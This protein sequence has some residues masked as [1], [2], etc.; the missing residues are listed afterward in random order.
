MIKVTDSNYHDVVRLLVK[1][2]RM[3]QRGTNLQNIP[4]KGNGELVRRCFVPPKGWVLI[5]AD[6]SSIEPRIMSHILWTRY[7]DNSMRGPYLEGGDPYVDVGMMVFDIPREWALDK[8]WYDPISK[9]GGTAETKSQAPDTAFQPRKLAKQGLLAV[10]YGQTAKAF[11]K[12]LGVDESVAEHFLK[13]FNEMYPNFKHKMVKEIVDEMKEKGFSQ[14][15]F[16]RKRRF[17][18]YQMYQQM[19]QRSE[20]ELRE[21][22]IKRKQLVQVKNPTPQQKKRFEQI[23][24]RIQELR[25]PQALAAANEREAFNSVIQGSGAD[26]LKMNG[27]RMYQICRERGW[28]FSASIHDELI[29]A[30]PKTDLTPETIEIVNDVMTKTVKLSVPLKSDTVL[31]TEWMEEVSPEDWD[32][33]KQQPKADS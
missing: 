22:Y 8:S 12:T 13:T 32:F 18:K 3:T 6:L 25:K 5:G 11:A 7:G 26:I 27:A 20:T 19:I 21:L 15:I 17:P 2:N 4:S 33:E 10:A 23:Q 31:M 30:V 16:G 9:T 28:M 14:T 1:D 29:I 24:Q